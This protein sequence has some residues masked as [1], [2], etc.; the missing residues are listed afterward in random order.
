MRRRAAQRC[1]AILVVAFVFASACSHGSS[2]EF[3]TRARLTP[4]AVAVAVPTTTP[5]QVGGL[6]GG[7]SSS[8]Q[9][10]TSGGGAAGPAAGAPIKLGIVLPLQGGQRAFGE[11]VLRTTQAYIEELNS[12]GGVNGSLPDCASASSATSA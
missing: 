7:G 6:L 1:Q 5:S 9:G 4:K 3:E 2:V 11:P 10:A 8:T 12:V